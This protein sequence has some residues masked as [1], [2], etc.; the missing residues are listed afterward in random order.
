M[1]VFVLF[2]L[3]FTSLTTNYADPVQDRLGKVASKPLFRDP[4]HD[5]AADPVV[6]WNRKERKWFMLY[7]NRRANIKNSTGVEWVH[8]TRIGIAESTNNGTTWKYRG[9][10]EIAYGSADITHWA[11]DVVYHAGSY[12]M[13]LTIVPGI[14]KDWNATRDI[15]HLTSK[16]LLKWKYESTLKLSSDR[17][18][19]A[20]LARLPNGSWRMWYN[21][22]R[23]KKSIY[24][25][26]SPDLYR[27]QDHGKALGERGEG[28]KVFHWKNQNWMV[29][30]T[31]KGLAIYGSDDHLNWTRQPEN[32]L[33]TPGKGIDDQVIGGHPD[34]VVSGERAYLFYFT[35]PG[36][37]GPNA[38]NDGYEQR[39]SSIQV[40]ELKYNNGVI[41]CDRDQ[42][43]R[44]NLQTPKD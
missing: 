22:E 3:A 28:P 14:F 43:T 6:I 4:V 29:I 23:D 8:G 2:V 37:Q 19:D 40:V 20:S 31:W 44:V 21:N 33:E 38:K 12:H 27:W 25:A 39:R 35:H 11:P 42:P 32:L 24:Y 7:T 26:D 13:Y 30:D 16:D 5:G 9:T 18:I 15:V 41:T 1:K 17:V 34:V 10:A 36:R